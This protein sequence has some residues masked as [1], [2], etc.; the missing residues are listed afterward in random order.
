MAVG[1][2]TS[3]TQLQA[4]GAFA[5]KDNGAT[6]PPELIP[7]DCP[8]RGLALPGNRRCVGRLFVPG[9]PPSTLVDHLPSRCR[10]VKHIP[11]VDTAAPEVLRRFDVVNRGFSGYNTSNALSVLPQIF[12]PPTPGGP[13]LKYLVSFWLAGRNPDQALTR[14]SSSCLVPTTRASSCPPTSSMC[15]STGTRR[16]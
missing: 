15:P 10:S 1:Y 11:E 4:R 7:S 9:C 12:A 14:T 8:V 2:L 13:E 16:T 6:P 5:D 3:P